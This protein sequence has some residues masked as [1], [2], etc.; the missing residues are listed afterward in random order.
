MTAKLVGFPSYQKPGVYTK[1]IR[2]NEGFNNFGGYRIP[3]FVGPASE[4]ILVQ[5]VPVVRG[6]SGTFPI[7]VEREDLSFQLVLGNVSVINTRKAPIVNPENAQVTNNV[8]HIE[9]IIDGELVTPIKLVGENASGQSE[10]HL[11]FIPEAGAKV[12]V[13]YYYIRRD[14]E[15]DTED[16]SSQV[17]GA[18]TTFFT[19]NKNIVDDT[20]SGAVTND[21]QFIDVLVNGSATAVVSLDGRNGRFTLANAPAAS[22]IITVSYRYSDF[23]DFVDPLPNKYVQSIVRVGNVPQR[24]DYTEGVDFLLSN[25]VTVD[26]ST[27]HNLHWGNSFSVVSLQDSE[28]FENSWI[29][30]DNITIRIADYK[31]FGELLKPVFVV[32]STATTTLEFEADNMIV[33]GT[34]RGQALFN[35]EIGEET[36]AVYSGVSAYAAL[37]NGATLAGNRID[38]RRVDGTNRKVFLKNPINPKTTSVYAVYHTNLMDNRQYKFTKFADD[39]VNP[40]EY[41]ITSTDFGTVPRIEVNSQ[42]FPESPFYT[43]DY[44]DARVPLSH[45]EDEL[46]TLSF[47]NLTGYVITSTSNSILSATPGSDIVGN[48]IT[49]G[50]TANGT[51]YSSFASNSRMTVTGFS[52]AANNVTNVEIVSAGVDSI[53]VRVVTP[54]VLETIGANVGTAEIFLDSDQTY[55]YVVTSDK[56][57]LTGSDTSLNEAFNGTL[58]EGLLR[59]E[60]VLGEPYLDPTTG[61]YFNLRVNDNWN[62]VAGSTQMSFRITK[63]GVFLES[64][65]VE[66]A[67]LN[68]VKIQ[69]P[70]LSTVNVGESIEIQTNQLSGDEPELGDTYYVSYYYYRLDWDAELYFRFSDVE[71]VYGKANLENPLSLSAKLAFDNGAPV[72]ALKPLEL[73][74]DDSFDEWLEAQSN[75]NPAQEELDNIQR[76]KDAIDSLV[77]PLPQNKK[78]YYILATTDDS[79]VWSHLKSHVERY[80]APEWKSERYMIAGFNSNR[81]DSFVLNRARNFKSDR[82]MLTYPASI[83]AD[84]EADDSTFNRSITPGWYIGAA[85]AGLASRSDLLPSEPLTRKALQGFADLSQVRNELQ[86]NDLATEGVTIVEFDDPEFRIRDALNTDVTSTLTREPTVTFIADYLQI[87]TRQVLKRFIARPYINSILGEIETVFTGFMN[88]MQQSNIITAFRNV[89]VE[90]HPSDPTIVLVTVE[91]SPVLPIKYIFVTFQI[92]GRIN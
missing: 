70:D 5:D 91:Y 31:V 10:I 75:T 86:L 87:L 71:S 19:K 20:N 55:K 78:P 40:A 7:F 67:G 74:T 44:L 24:S 21:P 90:E 43:D 42:P 85:I 76:F 65:T 23:Q 2:E 84:L 13:S 64:A 9:V 16:L 15:A 56:A 46:I 17:D 51:D 28:N 48:L 54:G 8:Q 69:V 3:T 52:N 45:P 59:N 50:M 68:G 60:G 57:S 34:G 29:L 89:K 83:V 37:P 1:S 66:E 61:V 47:E 33:D 82:V 79:Q 92:Q 26:A 49:Y 62:I 35:A 77:D 53:T 12:Y 36:F 80:S 27:F 11:P 18:T 25:E 4:L 81:S 63:D 73:Y 38:V 88:F 14:K 39:G 22:A 32:G 6:A 30:E 58:R 72:V 41:K